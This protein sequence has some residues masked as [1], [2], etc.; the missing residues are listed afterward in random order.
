MVFTKKDIEN[1][2]SN[3]INQYT[4]S[5]EAE[6]QLVQQILNATFQTPGIVE[7]HETLIETIF[8]RPETAEAELTA[9]RKGMLMTCPFTMIAEA[10][11][12]IT[13]ELVDKFC[14]SV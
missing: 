7:L 14:L 11:T 13:A 9:Y 1:E 3:L 5:T 8:E 4:G 2:I 10:M 12:A 6:T